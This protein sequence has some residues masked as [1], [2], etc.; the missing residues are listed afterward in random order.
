MNQPAGFEMVDG[1]V[2]SVEPMAAMFNPAM[3]Y[4]VAHGTVASFVA[5]A[6]VLAGVYAIEMLRGNRTAYVKKAL[7][8]AMAVGVIAAPLQAVTGDLSARF[9]AKSQP[10]KFAAMEAHFETEQ[11][12][13]LRIGGIPDTS[14]GVTRL[15]IKIPKLAS[16]MTYFD[17]NA[18]IR[19]LNSFPQ[20]EIPNVHLVHYPFQLM[21]GLGFFMIFVG[22]WFWA[23]VWW[24]KRVDPGRLQ[25]LA[26]AATL[27]MGFLAIELG[28][29][30]TEFGR[31]PW[32]IYQVMRTS[33][34]ATPRGGIA[35][36]FFVFLAVYM[37][38]SAGLGLVL[39]MA[40]SRSVGGESI[41]RQV[42]DGS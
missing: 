3:P 40:R 4:E 23:W 9:V 24:R 27:P 17:P 29:L 14:A 15:A 42:T 13:P 10:E 11:G 1:K 37:I 32:V 6:F 16:L 36:L 33:E 5:T 28:W 8:L 30:V 22:A 41:A 38:L 25:L 18:E 19:G 20:D 2:V 26:I 31:Q 7:V 35:G 39:F 12:A 34:G 21:V